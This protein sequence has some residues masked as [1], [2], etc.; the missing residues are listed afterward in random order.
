MAIKLFKVDNFHYGIH[1]EFFID[2]EDDLEQIEIEYNCELGD[3][4]YLPSGEVYIRH[5]DGYSGDKWII[6]GSGGS[7][8]SLPTVTTDDNG[9]VL[10]VIDGTWAKAAPSGGVNILH[11]NNVYDISGEF[12][13]LDK[14]A[15]EIR[16]AFPWVI[17][18]DEYEDDGD[19]YIYEQVI[20]GI[21]QDGEGYHFYF[22]DY[23]FG[24]SALTDNPRSNF[25]LEN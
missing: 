23:Y 21:S 14:T 12:S 24:A 15:G 5:S 19:M 6:E 20:T 18:H 17:V 3:K 8:S 22:N 4:A 1:Q 10:T 16:E 11:V 13:Y 9:D 2:S 7:E 25:S